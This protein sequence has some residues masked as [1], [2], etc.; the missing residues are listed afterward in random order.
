[1]GEGGRG[2]R[3]DPR[4]RGRRLDPDRGRSFSFLRLK[5]PGRG[6]RIVRRRCFFSLS[7][8]RGAGPMPPCALAPLKKN[9]AWAFLGRFFRGSD[10]RGPD[11]RCRRLDRPRA[12]RVSIAAFRG[13]AANPNPAA[14]RRRP[15]TVNRF[16]DEAMRV[17]KVGRRQ[18]RRRIGAETR[19]NDTGAARAILRRAFVCCCGPR[20]YCGQKT[21]FLPPPRTWQ[22]V[23][24]AGW[25][26][27]WRRMGE[28]EQSGKISW[29]AS[30]RRVFPL[31]SV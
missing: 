20:A 27:A 17:C 21:F 8:A 25:P 30:E 3:S 14:S 23:P 7:P 26:P 15:S 2:R 18:R 16:G 4:S 31:G 28:A 29:F 11:G 12:P 9:R 22:T 1:M 5:R 24:P 13:R 10:Q 6:S 19:R